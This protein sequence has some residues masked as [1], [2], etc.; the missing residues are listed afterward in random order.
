MTCRRRESNLSKNIFLSKLFDII[1]RTEQGK[2]KSERRLL[3]KDEI[4]QSLER[5]EDRVFV[6]DYWFCG[7]RYN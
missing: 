7:Y 3:K 1:Y 4:C 5:K 2:E 6:T